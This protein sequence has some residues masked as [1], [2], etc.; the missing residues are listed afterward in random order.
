[1]LAQ[2][3]DAAAAGGVERLMQLA[4]GLVGV[5]PSVMDNIDIDYTLDKYSALLSNDP[6]MIRSPDAVKGIRDQ[7]AKQQ[8]QA[9]MAQQADTAQKLAAGAKTLSET[10]L[11]GG[12]GNALS[13]LTGGG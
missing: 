12:Q 3:Q 10:Q 5:D 4:G 2:A 8:Q 7:R 11:A 13:A 1:M 6:K 9:E